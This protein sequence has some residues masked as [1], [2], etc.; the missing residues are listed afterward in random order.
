MSAVFGIG[1]SCDEVEDALSAYALG[2][3]DADE[4]EAID[5]HL[6]GCER[7]RRTLANELDTVASLATM[8]MPVVPSPDV[9]RQLLR[10]AEGPTTSTPAEPISF[11]AARARRSRRLLVGL[12]AAAAC[13]LFA[14]GLIGVEL[15]DTR[16][17]RDASR[18]VAQ[19]LSTYISSGGQVVTLQA[20]APEIYKYYE[21]QGSLL[22]APGMAPVVVVAEC[23][24]SG[25]HLTYWV[26]FARGGERTAAGKLT[27]G[28]NGSGWL[29][30][31][32]DLPIEQFD[33]IGITIELED[34]GRAD[35]LVAPLDTGLSE[36]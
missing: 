3:L 2:V 19:L 5:E 20:Q 1:L 13:L 31:T 17:Q 9:R 4:I 34:E 36:G 15:R 29:A 30:V 14:M 12:S 26:W 24:E 7:C 25:D 23:P 27:V 21:G 35:V 11:D 16:N 8:T 10:Q 28:T 18:N 22:L 33:T 6:D 32:S